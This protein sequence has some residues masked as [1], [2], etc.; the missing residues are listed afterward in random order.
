MRNIEASPW[1]GPTSLVS[2]TN[3][4]N[5]TNTP[6]E[7]ELV[8]TL[9]TPKTD[10]NGAPASGSSVGTPAAAGTAADVAA[11]DPQGATSAASAA[12][13]MGAPASAPPAAAAPQA[14]AAKASSAPVASTS[15]GR[16]GP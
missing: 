15:K 1:M 16:A 6:Y 3:V 5:D 14:T 7:F 11:A 9:T 12:S 10:E 4:H 2:T 8:V 13:A